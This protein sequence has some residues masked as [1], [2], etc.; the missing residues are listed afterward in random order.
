MKPKT[1]IWDTLLQGSRLLN[2]MFRLN[3]LYI[4]LSILIYIIQ[5]FIP[6]LSLMAMQG[7][8]NTI[9][10][11]FGA[12]ASSVI[13]QF[14]FFSFI[15]LL[16]NIIG[17]IQGFVEGNLEARVSKTLNVLIC[18][19]STYLGLEDFENSSI[20]DK[21]KRA[22]SEAAYRPYQ[23]YTQLVNMMSNCVTLISSAAILVLWKWWVVIL[24]II[25]ST[26]SIFSTIKV[27]REQFEVFM[28]R[29]PLYRQS[30]YMTYLLT[31]DQAVKEVK[32]FQLGPYLLDRYR[33]F[34]DEFYRVD[35]A[36]LLKR[37]NYNLLYGILELGVVLGLIWIA[38]RDT[39][40]DSLLLGSLYGYIQAITLS[41]NQ[42]RSIIQG[43][44]QFS[45]NNLYLNQMFEFLALPTSDPAYRSPNA[46]KK[47]IVDFNIEKVSFK[48]VTFTYPGQKKN[49][50]NGVSFS[51]T[52]GQVLAIVG[53]NGSGKSTLVKLLMQLY[54]DYGGK[55]EIN[56]KNIYSYNTRVFQEKIGVV[57]QDFLKYE[58]SARHNVGFGSIN[59][60]SENTEIHK[61]IEYAGLEEVVERLPYGLETQLGR[62][63][64]EG[65]QLS[66][67]QWQRIAIAR[68]FMRN[69]DMYIL[70]EPSA[71]LDPIA[72]QELLTLFQDL[73]KDK[74]GIFIT[75]RISSAALAD[76]ILVMRDG[77]VI[78]QGTHAQLMDLGGYYNRLF[79]VQ[80]E[81]FVQ[82]TIAMS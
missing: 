65:Y 72:E 38:V 69:A 19:K 42:I 32:L 24:L 10:S 27:N 12:T 66:G 57:F 62:W 61:A 11:S 82:K 15:I 2:L 26:A 44:L 34:M 22:S 64:E 14:A 29:T 17:T 4:V 77:E 13:S 47:E 8:L 70:D 73:M 50:L 41:Q 46:E 31:N 25:A 51:I 79:R 35:K 76:Y 81:S 37:T 52:K 40:K 1:I 54:N 58:M 33:N 53:E 74:I 39:L 49:A 55:I 59:Q 9:S 36:I 45:Q 18:E 48:N 67:G 80:A 78:E 21:L 28:K 63:F 56:D 16:K 23:M 3:K 68:A 20:N 60:L 7:L 75:H 30:W 5:G 71:F 43:M 6:V